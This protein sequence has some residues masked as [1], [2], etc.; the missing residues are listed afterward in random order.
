MIMI[1]SLVLLLDLLTHYQAMEALARC[2][3]TFGMVNTA[4]A[5]FLGCV[6]IIRRIKLRRPAVGPSR[7]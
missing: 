5:C 4:L 2:V 3:L 7:A 6:E 1:R